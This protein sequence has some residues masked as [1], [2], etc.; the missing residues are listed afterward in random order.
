MIGKSR[1]TLALKDC[2]FCSFF[3]NIS[4]FFFHLAVTPTY[5]DIA[6]LGEGNTK[7]TVEELKQI[8]AND[9]VSSL[10]IL[11]SVEGWSEEQRST[12]LDLY[13]NKVCCIHLNQVKCTVYTSLDIK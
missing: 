4:L 6:S 10:D 5:Q 3:V 1:L 8:S 2:K 13:Q 12:L 11:G 9:L 7:W